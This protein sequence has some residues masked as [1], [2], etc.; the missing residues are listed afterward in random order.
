MKIRN[1]K[2]PKWR[3]EAMETDSWSS[4]HVC[5][6]GLLACEQ[7]PVHCRPADMWL[8]FHVTFRKSEN[9]PTSL[10]YHVVETFQSVFFV[11]II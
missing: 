7:P 10:N 4:A 8:L 9:V 11:Y 5:R 6:Q 1:L 2:W 3:A